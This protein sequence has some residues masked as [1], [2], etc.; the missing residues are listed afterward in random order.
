MQRFVLKKEKQS[1]DIYPKAFVIKA[2]LGDTQS[3]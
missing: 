3:W 1:V 2:N